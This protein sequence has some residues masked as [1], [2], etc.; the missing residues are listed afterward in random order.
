MSKYYLQ[1]GIHTFIFSIPYFL[2]ISNFVIYLSIS[3]FQK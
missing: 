1:A 2:S 3:I